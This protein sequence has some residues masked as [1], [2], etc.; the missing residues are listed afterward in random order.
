MTPQKHLDDEQLR[1]LLLGDADSNTMEATAMHLEACDKCQQALDALAASRELWEKAATFISLPLIAEA[2]MKL[3]AESFP[4]DVGADRHRSVEPILDEPSH[5]EMLGRIAGYDIEREVGRG[6]MGVVYKA[7]DMELN[8][9][10]AIK[11]LSPQLARHGTARQRF[12]REA[13]AAAA[14]IHPNVVAVYGVGGDEMPYLVMQYVAGPSLQR[15]VSD[16]GPLE[17]KD[18]VRIALQLAAALGAAHAQ[19]LVHRDIK[20]ANVLVEPDVSRVLV[21]D[22]GLARAIGDASMTQSGCFVGTPNYMSPEQASGGTIDA[23]SDLFSVGSVMYFMAAGQMPFRADSP[24]CVLNRIANDEPTPAQQLNSEIS[25]PLCDVID[26]L[27]EKDP[28][29]RFQSADELREILEQYL[30][31]L[32][33]PGLSAAPFVA[34]PIGQRSRKSASP[35]LTILKAAVVPLFLLGMAIGAWLAFPG[36]PNPRLDVGTANDDADAATDRNNS[37]SVVFPI[38]PGDMLDRD[39]DE[40]YLHTLRELPKDDSENTMPLFAIRDLQSFGVTPEG[41]FNFVSDSGHIAIVT[42][43]DRHVTVEMV[44]GVFATDSRGAKRLAAQYPVE[45]LFANSVLSLNAH[46]AHQPRQRSPFQLIKLVVTLPERFN[47]DVRTARGHLNVSDVVGEVR[48]GTSNGNVFL[49]NVTGPIVATSSSGHVDLKLVRQPSAGSR[50]SSRGGHTRVHLESGLA[51]L[52][53]AT[54]SGGRIRS[55]F[56][57]TRRGSWDLHHE[58]NGGGPACD[59]DVIGGDAVFDYTR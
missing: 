25:R 34:R 7:F 57:F 2:K 17:E 58:L 32:H 53:R 54:V 27:L 18:V 10:L 50:L 23:R 22:F 20:P 11:V 30:A 41:T 48:V 46:L 35:L 8:R 19:G 51:V 56:N 12:A 36:V 3:E 44:R 5:P 14:V 43:D 37:Q 52:L 47:L 42:G 40:S 1:T 49:E 31:F 9:P 21:T 55:S 38:E 24:L 4:R 6:G 13:R 28:D 39:S 29:R 16:Q 45:G 26:K 33:Q 59:V 15:L